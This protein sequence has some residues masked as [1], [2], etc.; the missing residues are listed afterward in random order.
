MNVCYL[1]EL[2][3][4][5]RELMPEVFGRRASA[6]EDSGLDDPRH[7]EASPG[8]FRPS[9]FATF[10]AIRRASL[11]FSN[12]QRQFVLSPACPLYPRKMG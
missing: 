11:C 2:F 4:Q 1:G 9:S 7:C 6:L 8:G 5:F 10:T 3:D 12:N